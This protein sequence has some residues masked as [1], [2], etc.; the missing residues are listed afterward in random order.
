M[1]NNDFSPFLGKRILITGANGF[2]GTALFK[3]LIALDFQNLY[4]TS[5]GQ[6]KFLYSNFKQADFSNYKEIDEVLNWSKPDMILNTAAISSIE[7]AFRNPEVAFRVNKDA[8]THIASWCKQNNSRLVHF[9]TDFVFDGT[10]TN[11]GETD[12]PKPLSIYGESKLA[13]EEEITKI[14][15]GAVIIRPIL[16]F[17]EKE[18]WHRHNFYTWLRQAI[19]EQTTVS[20]TADQVRQPTY[21]KDLV[22]ATLALTFSDHTGCFHI[23][24]GETVNMMDFAHKIVHHLGQDSSK[25]TS[26]ST[27]DLGAPEKRPLLSGFNL[28]KSKDAIA[29][30]PKSIDQVLKGFK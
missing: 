26:I 7:S 30:S 2:V 4:L 12:K 11:L 5:S 20:I 13:G 14:N 25:L 9:S 1:Q 8:P 17:G 3:E 18:T 16:V 24:G 10:G 21:I 29:Y 19:K 27:E 28:T 23:S 15:C 22:Q 6:N